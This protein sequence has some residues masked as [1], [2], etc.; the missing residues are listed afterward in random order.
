MS[1]FTRCRGVRFSLEYSSG[2]SSFGVIWIN[3]GCLDPRNRFFSVS[4][5]VAHTYLSRLNMRR[6][7][8]YS[9]RRCGSAC[10]LHNRGASACARVAPSIR[11]DVVD[12]VGCHLRGVDDDVAHEC[13]VQEG[14]VAEIMALVVG[15]DGAKVGVGI[16]NVD[17]CGI[18]ALNVDRWGSGRPGNCRRGWCAYL[19]LRLR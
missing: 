9:L 11:R 15:D 17:R 14:F 13:A 2:L 10:D 6:P 12:G 16:A 18:S 7:M 19:H 5:L 4:R 3:D 1:A 8:F